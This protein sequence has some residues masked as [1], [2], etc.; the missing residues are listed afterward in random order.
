[1]ATT[2]CT[3]QLI[4]KMT[5]KT[6]IRRFTMGADKLTYA[7]LKKRVVDSFGDIRYKIEYKDDEG[8]MIT[9]SSD[10]EL[11]EAKALALSVTPAVLRIT[12]VKPDKKAAAGAPSPD[13]P[14]LAP[15]LADLVRNISTQLPALAQQLPTAVR[16][17][18]PNAELDIEATLAATHDA[19]HKAAVEAANVASKTASAFATATGAPAHRT[20]GGGP[21]ASPGAAAGRGGPVEGF[22]P[23]VTCDRT[24]VGPIVGNRYNLRGHDYD[25]CE[26]EFNKLDDSEKALYDKIPPKAFRCGD[27]SCAPKPKG[28]G[29]PAPPGWSAPPCFGGGAVGFHPGVS[30][31]RTGQCPIVGMRYHLAGHNYDLCQAEYDKLGENERALY[32]PVPP[33]K[34]RHRVHNAK[35]G[36]K[37]DGCAGSRLAARFVCDVTIPDGMQVTPRAKF[38]KIWKIKNIGDVA[39]PPGAQLLFVGGDNLGHEMTVPLSP[40]NGVNPGDEVDV[41]VEMVAPAELGRYMGYWR[42]AGPFGRRRFGQRI[43]VHVHVVDPS[44]EACVPS[45]A[46]MAKVLA[47]KEMAAS[48]DPYD[49]AT[50]VAMQAEPVVMEGATMTDAAKVTNGTTMTEA[51]SVS[52]GT[53]MTE[54]AKVAE[55][56]TM[57]ESAKVAEGGTMTDAT[58]V[59]D[60]GTMTPEWDSE[61]DTMLDDLNE[62]GFVDRSANVRL[63]VENAG[64]LTHTVR[65]LVTSAKEGAATATKP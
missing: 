24:N 41:A 14:P 18:L 50:D 5:H 45:E 39:W 33:V 12:I 4:V 23:G 21:F 17:M 51:A 15:E 28:C 29:P 59:S 25:L 48:D 34:W 11:D 55:G 65:A 57:T 27:A 26:A 54:S 1:M 9:M 7:T 38:T 13:A 49:D 60:G 31:D 37:G 56:G 20:A 8:D 53:T 62:M 63:L 44:Q 22:H 10:D 16:S 30:C 3:D 46:E 32:T 61:W 42:L 43:W 40:A 6:E 52:N 19:C 58:K 35:H 64:S 47:A 36:G 2:K